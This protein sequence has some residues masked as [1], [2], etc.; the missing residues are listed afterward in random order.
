MSERIV[1]NP[2]NPKSLQHPGP[3]FYNWGGPHLTSLDSLY[4]LHALDLMHPQ[5]DQ[6]YLCMPPNNLKGQLLLKRSAPNS[7]GRRLS[8]WLNPYEQLHMR[9]LLTQLRCR[10]LHLFLG[11][12]GAH[13]SDEASGGPYYS[14]TGNS[15]SCACMHRDCGGL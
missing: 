9:T 10:G 7:Q 6:S 5:S 13:Y 15:S 3:F 2:T 14:K 12:P 4:I 11:P 8:L 1:L